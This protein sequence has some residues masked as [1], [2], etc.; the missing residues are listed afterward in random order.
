M[1]QTILI[2]LLAFVLTFNTN[3][4]SNGWTKDDNNNTFNNCVSYLGKYANLTTEQKETIA[5]CYQEEICKTYTKQDYQSKTDYAI[6]Q[7]TETTINLC[8]NK[9]GIPLQAQKKEETKVEVKKADTL[10]L[11]PTKENL[12]GDWKDEESEFSLFKTGDFVRT[13]TDG[14]KKSKGTWKI[15][16]DV[17][18]LY[19]E[20]TLLTKQ[21]DYKILM[22][23]KDKFIY[24]SVKN[25]RDT[26]TV[27]RI[28]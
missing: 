23:A 8:S 15:D 26:Y 4:Q 18:T 5:N 6:K 9:L 2:S 12:I 25:K 16:G 10:E 1:K 3:A 20:K 17:L 28:K 27:T 11:K 21:K 19:F 7:I 24:Q 13:E 22:F 14:G